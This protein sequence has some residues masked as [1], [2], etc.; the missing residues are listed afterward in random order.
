M[1]YNL[2][3]L[4]WDLWQ[5]YFQSSVYNYN[6]TVKTE[7]KNEIVQW[8]LDR[9]WWSSH[10]FI[11]NSS[12]YS[13]LVIVVQTS[14]CQGDPPPRPT[15]KGKLR[16]IRSRPTLKGEIEGD[17][18]QAHTQGE[19]WGGSGP[20]QHPRGKFREIRT[21]PPPPRLLMRAV[22]ILLECILVV[23]AIAIVHV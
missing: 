10:L 23:I 4:H 3:Q 19:N 20:G 9:D 5:S 18:I 14:T 22:H 12:L 21:R 15:L 16:G 1:S 8:R 2:Q 6:D 11:G 13:L 17:Q 7:Q